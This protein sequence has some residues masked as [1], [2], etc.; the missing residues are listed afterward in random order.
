MGV[1]RNKLNNIR[2]MQ[3]KQ[4][5]KTLTGVRKMR[6]VSFDIDGLTKRDIEDIRKLIFTRRQRNKVVEQKEP[7]KSKW[8]KV[9]E[10]MA[11]ENLL[12]GGAGKE[13]RGLS[14]EFREDF[15]LREP[16]HFE[17]HESK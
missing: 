15:T 8:A 10:E 12:S 9:A 17:N 7:Q 1:M 13:L 14:R 11:S 4:L 3:L 16:P 5:T 6:N 2:N